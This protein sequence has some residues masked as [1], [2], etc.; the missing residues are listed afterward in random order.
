[1]GFF[2]PKFKIN[3]FFFV[4]LDFYVV[5]FFRNLNFYVYH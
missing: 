1:M 3:V 2:G 5:L 4:N